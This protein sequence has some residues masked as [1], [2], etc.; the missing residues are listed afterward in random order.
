MGRGKSLREVLDG[1]GH[2]AEGVTTAKSAYDLSQR[3]GVDMPITLGV[4]QVLYESKPLRQAVSDLMS[5]QPR[6]EF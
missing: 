2:V 3:L 1:L 6:P 5:R 4:Y